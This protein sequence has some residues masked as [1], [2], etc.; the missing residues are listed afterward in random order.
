[1]IRI[2]LLI[3]AVSLPLVAHPQQPKDRSITSDDFN[4]S[5]PNSRRRAGRIRRYTLASPPLDKALDVDS[6]STLK[7]G[8]TLWKVERVAGPSGKEVAKRVEAGTQF[9]EGDLLRLSIESP[10]PGY[11]YVINRDWFTDGSSGGD[12]NLIFPQRGEDNRL[13][14]GRLIDIPAQHDEPF[15]ATPKAN[16]AG[17]MLTII[18]TS[19][20]LSFPLTYD[21]LPVSNTQLVAWERKWSGMTERFEMNGGVGQARTVEEQEAASPTG[22]RQLTRNDPAPQTIYFLVPRSSDGLLFN[23]L[24][25]YI[26]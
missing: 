18:V 11:L 21:P 20:P 8:V 2:F 4:K 24:L 17:E 13:E 23:L 25:S 16:Q 6:P 9:H 3:L 12:T 26:R 1:M 7:A 22:T 10:R 5:R 14:A 15:K 19:A